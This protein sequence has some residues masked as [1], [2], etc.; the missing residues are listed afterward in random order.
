M[1]SGTGA[2][3]FDEGWK[4]VTNDDKNPRRMNRRRVQLFEPTNDRLPA[5]LAAAVST[6][7]DQWW[8]ILA[9]SARTLS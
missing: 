4:L 1:I 3:I 7:S 6:A 5:S 2:D 8:V 9:A